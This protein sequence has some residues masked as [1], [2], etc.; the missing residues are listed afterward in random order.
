VHND[1]RSQYTK[2]LEGKMSGQMNLSIDMGNA[3]FEDDPGELARILRSLADRVEN[4]VSDGDEFI[5]WDINGNKVGKA[6]V[7]ADAPADAPSAP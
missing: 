6:E 2:I 1:D 3:A 5:L 7:V 4:G